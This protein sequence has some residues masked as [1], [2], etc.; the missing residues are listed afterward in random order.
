MNMF[1]NENKKDSQKEKELYKKVTE[2]VLAQK[3]DIVT[4][5]T[6]VGDCIGNMHNACDKAAA[7]YV[8]KDDFY[9]SVP[10]EVVKQVKDELE[11][12]FENAYVTW[13]KIINLCHFHSKSAN[14]NR[15]RFCYS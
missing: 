1:F 3:D 14:Q 10:V 6:D 9:K 8:K 5:A 7:D 4:A 2:D 13:G 11:P 12:V 15:S